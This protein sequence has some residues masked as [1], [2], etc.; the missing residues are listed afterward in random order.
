VAALASADGLPG[1]S[2]RGDPAR[3][4]T[5][6]CSK[7]IDCTIFPVRNFTGPDPEPHRR[8]CDLYRSL[9]FDL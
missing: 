2:N 3:Q 9:F 6:R 7:L 4:Q 5:L 1:D 8:F